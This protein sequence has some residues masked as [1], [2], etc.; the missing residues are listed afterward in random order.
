MATNK[1][2]N[3]PAAN[4]FSSDDVLAVEENGV[5]FVEEDDPLL[6]RKFTFVTLVFSV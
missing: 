3:L 2:T 5:C 1:I 6:K 4:S